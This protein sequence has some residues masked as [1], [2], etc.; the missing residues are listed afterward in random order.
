M[1]TLLLALALS[2]SA[3]CRSQ[4][5]ADDSL[6]WRSL[7]DGETTR[8]W[9]GFKRSD[10]PAGWQV[11]DG[12]LARLDQAGDLITVDTFTDFVL[13]LE[14]KISE[15]GN[16]GI[17][18]HVTED[19]DYVWES[20]P[21]LQVLDNEA[22]ENGLDPRTSAGSNYALHAPPRDVTRAPGEWNQVRLEVRDG[23]VSH[24]LNGHHLFT[25]ELGSPE[26]EALVAASKFGS[27]PG[28]GRAGSGHIALQD[29]GDDVWFR[30]L[31]IAEW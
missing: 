9:R 14:W 24:H 11:Q 26:W 6:V 13:E 17:F 27:M 29:H 18:F 31:R 28:Y 16:S 23:R 8:G 1:K 22:H 2:L 15:G 19:H 4:S 30:N 12:T 5:P 25:Y 21:E 3:A 7:F 10:V 20:G